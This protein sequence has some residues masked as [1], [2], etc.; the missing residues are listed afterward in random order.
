MRIKGS[1]RHQPSRPAVAAVELAILL[2]VLA[3]IVLGCID[4]GRFAYYY[5]AVV[6]S[7]RAGAAYGMMNNYTTSTLPNWKG[8]D[9]VDPTTGITQAARDEMAQQIGSGNVSN[10]TVTVTPSTDSGSS[11]RRVKV[12]VTY[13]FTTIVNWNWFRLGIPSSMTLRGQAEVRLIR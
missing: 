11:G 5:I 8:D 4:F 10:V 1:V 6:N 12:Q 13:P 9:S 3:T 7:A 2:P